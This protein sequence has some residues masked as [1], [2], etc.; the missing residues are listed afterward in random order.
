MT[1]SIE[2]I[3]ED[4]PFAVTKFTCVKNDMMDEG[5]RS[6]MMTYFY[7]FRHTLKELEMIARQY[8]RFKLLD[9]FEGLLKRPIIQDELEK[10]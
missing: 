5:P 2:Q 1:A 9:S 3:D 4:F 8:S 10:K 7:E 6:S